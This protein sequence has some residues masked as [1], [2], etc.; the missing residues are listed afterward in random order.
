MNCNAAGGGGEGVQKIG[1]KGGGGCGGSGWLFSSS[2]LV[3]D[4]SVIC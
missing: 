1:G 4:C 2:S 3:A